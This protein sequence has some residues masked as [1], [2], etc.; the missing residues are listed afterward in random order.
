M[1][2]LKGKIDGHKKKIL[3]NTPPPKTKSCNC[4][5]KVNC[6]MREPASLKMFYTMA[7]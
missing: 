2:N 7:K 4:L 6:L 1:P 3:E 5:K